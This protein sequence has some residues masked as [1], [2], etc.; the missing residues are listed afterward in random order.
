MTNSAALLRFAT[1][2]HI[3]HHIPGRI[4]LKLSPEGERRLLQALDEARQFGAV[5]KGVPGIRAIRINAPA[6]SCVVDY[7]PALIPP[8][9]W[10][11]L[12]A[13][14]SSAA[15]EGLVLALGGGGQP[16]TVTLS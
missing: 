2:L 9:A 8:A 10:H 15:A 3:A 14:V 12:V 13:G 5:M 16:E 7:D 6:R 1:L 11:D 4:R